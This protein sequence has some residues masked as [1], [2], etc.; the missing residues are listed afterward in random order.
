VIFAVRAV[1]NLGANLFI[2][3]SYIM[4]AV[5]LQPEDDWV[6]YAVDLI[7]ACGISMVLAWF[8]THTVIK[9]L[10]LNQRSEQDRDRFHEEALHDPLT[11]LQN[12]RSFDQSVDFYI[13]VCSRVHQT[14]CVVMLDIDS[15]K[16][17]NDCYGHP[18]GDRV[19]RSISGVLAKIALDERLFVARVGGEEFIALWT[20]NRISEAERI[21]LKL[22]EMVHELRIPHE[23]SGVLPIV[24][25][26]LGLYVMRGGTVCTP[27]ELYKNADTALYTAK[28]RG[29]DCIVMLD[30]ATMEEQTVMIRPFEEAGRRL[31]WED[32]PQHPRE[33]E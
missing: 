6:F 10:L 3:V 5:F 27:D 24:T 22:R 12:R 14:V 30:S 2:I 7:L 23:R 4:V 18:Q 16:N 33:T 19:L 8:C 15:F 31:P 13:N 21:V 17:Y 20:E 1:Y 29:K 25:V 32:D 9:E 28:A 26:S 11:G